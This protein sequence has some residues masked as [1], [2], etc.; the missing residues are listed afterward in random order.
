VRGTVERLWVSADGRDM[1][2]AVGGVSID[3]GQI[4]TVES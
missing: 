3:V 2:L 4:V 1:K